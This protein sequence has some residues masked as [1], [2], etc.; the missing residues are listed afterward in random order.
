MLQ[1]TGE[2]TNPLW[3]SSGR[4]QR[5]GKE[6]DKSTLEKFRKE[7]LILSFAGRVTLMSSALQLIPNHVFSTDWVP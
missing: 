6:N 1:V 7:I 4:K 2:N 3:K 5:P